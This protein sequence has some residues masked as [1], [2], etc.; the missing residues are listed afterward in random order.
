MAG[1]WLRGQTQLES[2]RFRR[3]DGI[4][5]FSSTES[6]IIQFSSPDT[7]RE[8]RGGQDGPP[9]GGRG[10]GP[11]EFVVVVSFAFFYSGSCVVVLDLALLAVRG[12]GVC[13]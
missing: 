4:K 9:E 5:L 13:L 2:S 1:W 3:N 8:G 7:T 11:D 12:W 6:S 10:Y